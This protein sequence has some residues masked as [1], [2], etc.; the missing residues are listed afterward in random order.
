MFRDRIANGP[1][2]KDLMAH[3]RGAVEKERRRKALLHGIY[4]MCGF[5]EVDW[6]VLERMERDGRKEKPNTSVPR[7]G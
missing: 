2:S 3:K 1:H 6:R 7:H 5:K 4:R